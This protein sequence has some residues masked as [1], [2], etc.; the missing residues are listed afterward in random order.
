[1]HAG[2]LSVSIIHPTLTRTKGSFTRAQMHLIAHGGCTVIVKVSALKVDYG[3][4]LP[5]CTGESNLLQQCAR[6][7]LYQL[8]YIPIPS[9]F[10]FLSSQHLHD[11]KMNARLLKLIQMSIQILTYIKLSRISLKSNKSIRVQNMNNETMHLQKSKTKSTAIREEMITRQTSN[12]KL[13]FN[14][15]S[16]K[17]FTLQ[18]NP[19]TSANYT[20]T[21]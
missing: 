3:R 16:T 12:Q 17:T 19:V 20:Q 18:I 21:K 1:M 13:C 8:G 4:K 6:Q 9:S 5:N 11:H 10:F 7:T 15:I 2:C 14:C